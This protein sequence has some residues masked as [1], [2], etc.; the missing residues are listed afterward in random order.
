MNALHYLSNPDVVSTELGE[1][2]VLLH[3][4]SQR[5]Y[6]VNETGLAIWSLLAEP[7]SL[8]EIVDALA[9]DFEVTRE[10]ART[11][12]RAFLDELLADGLVRETEG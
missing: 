5:Y 11:A 7:R 10:D 4:Q 2:A 1:E 3:L 12:A 6:T 9:Q 8:D